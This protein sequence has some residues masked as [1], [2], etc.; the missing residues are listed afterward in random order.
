PSLAALRD[1]ER[2]GGRAAEV[3]RQILAFSRQQGIVRHVVR[4]EEILR[5]T[6][7]LLRATWPAMIRI[8]LRVADDL[9]SVCA[10]AAQ[11]QQLVLNLATNARDAMGESGRLAV[12]VEAV[13]VDA[14]FAAYMPD[15]SAGSHLRL[16]MSDTGAGI[17]P[18]LVG[19]IFEP[20]FTT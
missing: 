2:A 9:P 8:D 6:L 20:F 12:E 5:E 13:M 3:V 7:G 14:A 1:V 10:D 4:L 11:L 15:L 17:A 18:E 19:R 16:T